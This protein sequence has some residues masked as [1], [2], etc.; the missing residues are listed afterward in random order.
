MIKAP[1]HL[2]WIVLLKYLKFHFITFFFP[3]FNILLKCR[4]SNWMH[5]FINGLTNV[6]NKDNTSIL[7]VFGVPLALLLSTS[8]VLFWELMFSC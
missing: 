2:H 3:I 7:V 5:Y 8:K 6:I 1:L 4:Y